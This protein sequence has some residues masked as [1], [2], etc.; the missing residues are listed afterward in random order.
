MMGITLAPILG[1][2]KNEAYI[3]DGATNGRRNKKDAPPFTFK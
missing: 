1:E 3:S 2:Y